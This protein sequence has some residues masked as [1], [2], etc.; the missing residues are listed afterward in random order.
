MGLEIE[1]KFLIDIDKVENLENG[2][3]IKQGY[4]QTKDKT[5]VRV[6]VK[7]D[8]AFIT[9]KGKN[10]GASRV[11]FEYSIPLDDANE[12]LEKLCSKPFIDKKRYLVEHKNHTWE[13]DVFHKENEGLIVAEVELEDENEIVELPK[14]IVKE[15]TGDARYYNSNLLENPFSKWETNL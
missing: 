10:V 5:T 11:E 4:I 15:V 13:I 1:R 9:I 6:R 2:Y 7:G 14:W 8:E 3:E 12:M